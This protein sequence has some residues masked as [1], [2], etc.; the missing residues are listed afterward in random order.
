MIC[1]RYQ[2]LLGLSKDAI[3]R[4]ESIVEDHEKY[5]QKLEETLR[6]LQPLE[7]QLVTLQSGDLSDNPQAIAQRMQILLSEKEQGEPKISALSLLAERILPDTAM[8]GRETIRNE[9]KDLRERW[10]KLADGNLT[11]FNEVY[12]VQI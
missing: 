8:S 10:E 5:Q 12:K 9:V 4:W 3:N 1:C 6:W 2:N 7:D 11:A